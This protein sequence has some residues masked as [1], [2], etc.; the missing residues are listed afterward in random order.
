[1]AADG[2]S[3]GSGRNNMKARQANESDKGGHCELGEH[4]EEL[5]SMRFE[6]LNC[7]PG[8]TLSVYIWVVRP[9]GSRRHLTVSQLVQFSDQEAQLRLLLFLFEISP[10]ATKIF[11][12]TKPRQRNRRSSPL[13]YPRAATETFAGSFPSPRTKP[14]KKNRKSCGHRFRF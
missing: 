7:Q 2:P 3:S 13:K 8:E 4:V 9:Q 6:V 14:W 11:V 10:A 1:M 12:I 5:V